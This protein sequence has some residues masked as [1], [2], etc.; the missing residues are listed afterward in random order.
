MKNFFISSPQKKLVML[1]ELKRSSHPQQGASAARSQISS[2]QLS[3]ERCLPMVCSPLSLENR[4]DAASPA[5]H[6]H[7]A[8]AGP[9]VL[10]LSQPFSP[11]RGNRY[12]PADPAFRP[13]AGRFPSGI[14][15]PRTGAPR[16]LPV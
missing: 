14:S 4:A 1:S 12:A 7:L 3:P 5:S 6:E 9:D 16:P 13:A 15:A 2:K 11:A 8:G 10:R